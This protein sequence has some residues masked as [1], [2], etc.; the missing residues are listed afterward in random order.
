MNYHMADKVSIKTIVFF[1]KKK[2]N[3]TVM[4]IKPT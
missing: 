4:L 1:E 2:K 3:N